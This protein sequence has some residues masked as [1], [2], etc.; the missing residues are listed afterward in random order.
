[1]LKK[2]QK[3]IKEKMN[4]PN[5]LT[6]IIINY[7]LYASFIQIGKNNNNNNILLLFLLI[8]MIWKSKIIFCLY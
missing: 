8:P 2:K 1:M 4:F 6:I 3:R 5:K 7:I